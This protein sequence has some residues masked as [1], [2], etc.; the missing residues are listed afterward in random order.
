MAI[1]IIDELESLKDFESWDGATYFQQRIMNDPEAL[2]V[3]E[4][5]LEGYTASFPMTLD[6]L[7]D[8]L[9]FD[10]EE[11]LIEEGIWQAEQ[12]ISI[13]KGIEMTTQVFSAIVLIVCIVSGVVGAMLIKRICNEYEATY[14]WYH[15]PFFTWVWKVVPFK[16][17]SGVVISATLFVWS[18]W[19]LIFH[20]ETDIMAKQCYY[21]VYWNSDRKER[22]SN[23]PLDFA[24]E[25]LTLGEAQTYAREKAKEAFYVGYAGD[26][27]SI[28]YEEIDDSTKLD[29][30][31]QISILKAAYQVNKIIPQQEYTE[32]KTQKKGLDRW[33]NIVLISSLK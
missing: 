21:T 7:N 22:L 1:K 2:R 26:V 18:V 33:L 28:W 14:V 23:N 31:P 5:D 20:Q 15:M 24:E 32:L 8:Y 29:E 6:E 30:P 19:Q 10:A 3:I 12:N 27:F 13:K 16:Y 9:W 4:S 17:L 25:F 11:L